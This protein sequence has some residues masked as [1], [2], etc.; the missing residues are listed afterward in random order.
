MRD[1]L[2]RKYFI[3]KKKKIIWAYRIPTFAVFASLTYVFMMVVGFTKMKTGKQLATI[4]A[5]LYAADMF[6]QRR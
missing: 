4:A 2:F 3:D 5:A 1:N 6:I